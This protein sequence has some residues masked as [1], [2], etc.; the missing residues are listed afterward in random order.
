M[1]YEFKK[2]EVGVDKKDLFAEE[3]FI[4]NCIIANKNCLEITN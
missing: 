2:R 1:N 4:C 3:T